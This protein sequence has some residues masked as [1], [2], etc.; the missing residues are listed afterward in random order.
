MNLAAH[1]ALCHYFH[2]H[3]NEI[4][5]WFNIISPQN[6]SIMTLKNE[7]Y[8]LRDKNWEEIV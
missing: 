6:A 1:M 4:E 5:N 7:L 3:I 8:I 2:S